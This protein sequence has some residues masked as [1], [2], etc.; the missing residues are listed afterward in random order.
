MH[1]PKHFAHDRGSLACRWLTAT[2]QT[3]DSLISFDQH[4][5]TT[6]ISYTFKAIYCSYNFA[7]QACALN[8]KCVFLQC[9]TWLSG[10]ARRSTRSRS[11]YQIN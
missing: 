11:S 10:W 7:W 3:I 9:K 5:L 4:D 1:Q 8:S 2:F 6:T